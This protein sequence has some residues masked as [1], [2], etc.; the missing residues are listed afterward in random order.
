MEYKYIIISDECYLMPVAKHLI[1]EGRDVTV[2]FI[3]D[4]ASL[5]LPDFKDTETPEDK[6]ERI[7]VYDGILPK[8]SLGEVMSFL[9]TVKNKDDYFVL[10]KDI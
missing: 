7:S 10:W 9:K 5:R 6:K 3:K 4:R 1:D 8:K 2:G